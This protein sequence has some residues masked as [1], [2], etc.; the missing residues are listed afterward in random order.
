MLYKQDLIDDLKDR[1]DLVRRFLF[2]QVSVFLLVFSILG[3]GQSK[4]GLIEQFG[5]IPCEDLRG[6]LD[7]LLLELREHPEDQGY[8]VIY[9]N[10]GEIRTNTI[11][12][13]MIRGHLEWRSREFD[14]DR[15]K[16]VRATLSDRFRIELWRIPIDTDHHFETAEWSFRVPEST[17][18]FIFHRYPSEDNCPYDYSIE[19]FA[20][21]LRSNPNAK[22]KIV[23]RGRSTK[24]V[25][26][27][28]R[29]IQDD[30][31]TRY[32]I[33]STQLMISLVT[34]SYLTKD[35]ITVEYWFVP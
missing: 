15:V 26:D 3:Q 21:F 16:I 30:L 22:G 20:E 4:A 29:Q 9:G 13:G 6:R 18:P 25:S 19:Y 35:N 2:I 17:G 23:I 32:K 31:S 5:K 10:A 34:R 11:Y 28:K 1:A 24:V 12:E 8:A 14:R 33:D 27:R 7:L